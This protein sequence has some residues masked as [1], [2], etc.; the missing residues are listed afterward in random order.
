LRD[1]DR[2]SSGRYD[3]RRPE[4]RRRGLTLERW[5]KATVCERR[6]G[7]E[8]GAIGAMGRS[9]L[10]GLRIMVLRIG[11]AGGFVG[12][13]VLGDLAV[14]ADMDMRIRED[15][16]QRRERHRQPSEEQVPARYHLGADSK[17]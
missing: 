13:T 10:V 6:T 14:S 17:P 16:A 11:V 12:G 3:M 7:A 15:G 8:A 5:C 2:G 1:A 4:Q 9:T